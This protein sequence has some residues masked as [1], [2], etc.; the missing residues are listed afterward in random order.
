[1]DVCSNAR[2]QPRR[3]EDSSQNRDFPADPKR[4]PALAAVI[5]FG[6]PSSI[7]QKSLANS[8]DLA[9]TAGRATAHRKKPWMPRMGTDKKHPRNPRN[10]WSKKSSA[11]AVSRSQHGPTHSAERPSDGGHET[12]RFEQQCDAAVRWSAW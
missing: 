3:A 10:P 1:M 6:N 11:T 7:T 9:V 2:T 5:W 4:F 12:R 8:N